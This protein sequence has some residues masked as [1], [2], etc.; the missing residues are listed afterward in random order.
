MTYSTLTLVWRVCVQGYANICIW[1][2]E[3]ISQLSQYY[4]TSIVILTGVSWYRHTANKPKALPFDA[5]HI[6]SGEGT[7]LYWEKSEQKPLQTVSR[8]IQA[9]IS[10]SV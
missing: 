10:Q 1:G 5:K 4:E 8:L 9:L 3:E 6:S 2:T 7:Q